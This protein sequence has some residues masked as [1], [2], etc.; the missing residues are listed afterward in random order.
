MARM[1]LPL[2]NFTSRAKK[3]LGFFKNFY[4]LIILLIIY[5]P[6]IVV[7]LLSFTGQTNRGNIVLN[8]NSLSFNNWKILFTN[9]AFLDS[10]LNSLII[11]AVVVPV[12]VFIGV[13]TCFGIWN[14]TKKK[15]LAVIG[16]SKLSI[17][18]PEPITA[19]SLA[20][21]F[22]STWVAMGL[23][24]GLITICLSHISFCTPYA[25]VTIY[26]K[27]QKMNKNLVM[28]SYDLGYSKV[29]TFLNIVIPYLLPAILS[30]AAITFAM[31]LDDFIITNLINGS[32]QT[33]STAIYTTR[34][35]IKAWVVTFGGFLIIITAFITLIAA[36]RKIRQNKTI[37]KLKTARHYENSSQ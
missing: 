6:L 4:V 12:S 34:K 2:N 26:P 29:K 23:N 21:L 33:I 11:S 35:G 22:S 3:Y 27:M 7:L 1:D 30:A 19:I 36:L 10:L 28:A 17:A 14:T 5:I 31:S 9:D 15:E 8:F 37:K 20:L 13:I 32:T 18:I 24:F 16:I 25:I